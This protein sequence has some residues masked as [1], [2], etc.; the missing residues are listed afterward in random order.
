MAQGTSFKE[1]IQM[2]KDEILKFWNR[3]KSRI[4]HKLIN[5][6]V[7]AIRANP[8]VTF[9]IILVLLVLLGVK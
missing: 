3:K 9:Y 8:K 2:L 1:N 7:E 4:S 6:P 5:I